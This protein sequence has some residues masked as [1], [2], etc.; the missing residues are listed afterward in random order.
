MANKKFSDFTTKT[1]TGDVDFLVGFDGSDNVKIAPDNLKVGGGSDTQIQFNNSGLLGGGS[2]LTT[3]KSNKLEVTY[4][5]GLKGDGG[6][7]QGL[8]KLYCEAGT[9]HHVGIK[10]PAHSGGTSYTLQLPN[11]L[12]NVANQILESNASGALSW[13]ATPSGGGGV[14]SIVAGSGIS[15]NQATGAVTVTASG[16]GGSAGLESGTGTNSMRSSAAISGATHT[17]SGDR[18]IVIAAADPLYGASQATGNDA[19]AI[20][21]Y[22]LSLGSG[23]IAIGSAA[24][25]SQNT[26]AIG[27][28]TGRFSYNGGNT[29]C[30]LIGNQ[31]GRNRNNYSTFV[32]YD[33]GNSA[34]AT[35]NVGIG[36]AALRNSVPNSSGVY[37]GDNTGIGKNAGS[38]LTTGT[39]CS[40]LGNDSQPSANNVT[41]EI[42]LGDSNIA[43][44][45]CAVTSITSLSDQRDK[46]GIT[47]LSYGLD[48]I[49]LLQPREFVWDNRASIKKELVLNEDGTSKVDE[50]GNSI[51][52]DVEFFSANKGK[53]DFGFIAQEVQQLDNDTLRLVYD[54][55][56]DKLEMSYGKLV[57]VLVKAVQEL[58]AEV[59]SLKAKLA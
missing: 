49:N 55:N 14:T 4:E 34:Q 2:F 41:N 36:F 15:V 21:K 11:T 7:N 17:A 58:S 59:E 23:A 33:A 3:N 10:G 52:E 25:A 39:N 50:D 19:V 13:I 54:A 18:A 37:A 57:P 8:L 47:N 32:G 16:G 38:T 29:G 24:R 35:Y 51:M 56:S 44:L 40:F 22:V 28:N 20:G 42:T 31:A 48:F 53:K 9:A 30:V 5:L 43:T 1:S 12:P 46:A 27:T 26:V 6:S 45:R